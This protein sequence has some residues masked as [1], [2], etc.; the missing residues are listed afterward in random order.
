MAPGRQKHLE[1]GERPIAEVVLEAFGVGLGDFGGDAEG[2]EEA[3]DDLVAAAG[4]GSE[5]AAAGREEDGA[6]GAG[7]DEA[8]ALEACDGADDGDVGDAQGA[9]DV[10]DAGL[11]AGVD[12]VGDGF[13]VVLGELGGVGAAGG[14]VGGGAGGEGGGSRHELIIASASCCSLCYSL[15]E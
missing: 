11:A 7:G 10:G 1:G 2:L 8:L 9:G 14:A 13:G 4:L 6:V 3:E 12:E 5:G 15:G